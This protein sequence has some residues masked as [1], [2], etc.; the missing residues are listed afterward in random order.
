TLNDLAES[1]ISETIHTLQTPS[2]PPAQVS[3]AALS[4][5]SS[6]SKAE[7]QARQKHLEEHIKRSKELMDQLA[8]ARSK[9]EKDVIMTVLRE[10]TRC[11]SNLLRAAPLVFSFVLV[12]D[13]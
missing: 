12:Y 5:A 4:P 10:H 6:T 2:L 7:L 9:A 13:L 11:V 8:R 1:F 3:V